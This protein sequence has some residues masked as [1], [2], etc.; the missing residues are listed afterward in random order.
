[1]ASGPESSGVVGK[2][3]IHAEGDAGRSDRPGASNPTEARTREEGPFR[4]HRHFL[5]QPM[6]QA[7]FDI[8]AED[9]GLRFRAESVGTEALEGKAKAENAVAALEKAG[10]Y[11]GLHSVKW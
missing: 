11:P 10:I 1:M 7:I 5:P 6:A 3:M 8:L 9:E 2:I 4:L